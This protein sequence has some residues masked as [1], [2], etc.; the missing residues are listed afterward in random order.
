MPGYFPNTR[1][2]ML[3]STL[4]VGV[5]LL[6]DFKG[7]GVK[8][9]IVAQICSVLIMTEMSGLKIT[10]LG[11]F[12]GVGKIQLGSMSTLFTVFAVVGGINAFNMIDG[13]DGLA[14]GLTLVSTLS[15]AIIAWL[16]Q[17]QAIFNFC[18][19]FIAVIMGFLLFNLRIFGRQHAKI[20]LGDTGSTLYGF[21]VCYLAIS[22]QG[23][24]PLIAPSLVLWIIAVP[25]IDLVCIML[26]RLL[27]G[28]SP[29]AA[30]R[31][32]IHHILSLS[33]YSVNEIVAILCGTSLMV[34][35]SSI[36]L[37]LVLQVSNTL[38]FLCFLI[39]FIGHHHTF[40]RVLTM[41]KITRYLRATQGRNHDR[42]KADRRAVERRTPTK[43]R[44]IADR[45]YI[46]SSA[47]LLNVNS[48]KYCLPVR[49]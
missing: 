8:I 20:F 21:T 24:H 30:D 10:E 27:R 28:R 37:N 42:R 45:R 1:A 38:L 13:I 40:N 15:I 32:H 29:F 44:M 14:G 7:L 25:L 39:F 19:L 6:D 3:A 11:Y 4:L 35:F 23:N 47:E 2:Y 26:R 33:G 46:P 22:I 31:E 5:G 36:F 9:R 16:F 43:R 41:I 17:D 18:L 48:G 12:W 34:S 49:R